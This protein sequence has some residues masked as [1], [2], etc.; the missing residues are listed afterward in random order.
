MGGQRFSINGPDPEK[1][2]LLQ[3]GAFRISDLPDP[4]SGSSRILTF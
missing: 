1:F 2:S 4:V 3:A